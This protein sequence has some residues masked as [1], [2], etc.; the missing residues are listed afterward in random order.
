MSNKKIDSENSNA[1]L[2]PPRHKG[3]DVKRIGV[4]YRLRNG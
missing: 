1:G 4:G 2:I 3:G